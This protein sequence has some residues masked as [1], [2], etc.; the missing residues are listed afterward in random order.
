MPDEL[1]VSGQQTVRICTTLHYFA[2]VCS[3]FAAGFQPE[4]SSGLVSALPLGAYRFAHCTRALH[5]PHA[6]PQKSL[7][8]NRK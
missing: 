7:L 5:L 4:P 1:P 6:D 2:P 3:D 8:G